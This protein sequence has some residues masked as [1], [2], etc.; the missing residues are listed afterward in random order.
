MQLVNLPN[1]GQKEEADKT[2]HVTTGLFLLFIENTKKTQKN[3]E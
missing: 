1:R 3:K 2:R